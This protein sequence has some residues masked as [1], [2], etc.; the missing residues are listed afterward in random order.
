LLVGL[1]ETLQGIVA[2]SVITFRVTCLLL[3]GSA[4]AG[5]AETVIIREPVGAAGFTVIVIV[6]VKG[7]G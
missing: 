7:A 4:P 6:E 1:T 3:G 5:S 2:V